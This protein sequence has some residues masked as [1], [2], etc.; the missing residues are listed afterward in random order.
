MVVEQQLL[1]DDLSRLFV[2]SL[3]VDLR[4]SEILLPFF[5]EAVVFLHQAVFI[6]YIALASEL[7]ILGLVLR[8]NYELK[9]L[10]GVVLKAVVNIVVAY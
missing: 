2:D 3:A 6:R 7:G 1:F 10:V 4:D 5:S 8:P 9:F